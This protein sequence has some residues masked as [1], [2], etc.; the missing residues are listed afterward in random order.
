MGSQPVPRPL[1]MGFATR[2]SCSLDQCSV[3]PRA[4]EGLAQCVCCRRLHQHTRGEDGCVCRRGRWVNAAGCAHLF[5]NSALVGSCDFSGCCGASV[6][7]ATQN[8]ACALHTRPCVCVGLPCVPD[9]LVYSHR[10]SSARCCSHRSRRQHRRIGC[11][12]AAA[13]VPRGWVQRPSCTAA[14]RPSCTAETGAWA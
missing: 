6:C 3:F 7:S 8:I 2:A 5:L 10:L 12:Q 9:G 4:G 14:Q 13:N 11:R 1:R